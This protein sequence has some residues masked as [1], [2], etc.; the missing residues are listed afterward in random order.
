VPSTPPMLRPLAYAAAV[1][2]VAVAATQANPS[3]A[4]RTGL[5]FWNVPALYLEMERDLNALQRLDQ[6]D[7]AILGQ[8]DSKRVVAEDV[9]AG[10]CGFA[11]GVARL[12]Q[13]SGE[14]RKYVEKLRLIAGSPDASAGELYGH[15]LL[16]L[17]SMALSDEPARQAAE[18]ARLEA[19]M[20]S[21][22]SAGG[23]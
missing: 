6:K 21:L 3:W 15:Q 2:G 14:D 1:T 20:Q 23:L 11:E 22:K 9:I 8:I 4:A 13:I 5:D 7:R 10:R 17:V 12:K 19:E 16:R 18:T